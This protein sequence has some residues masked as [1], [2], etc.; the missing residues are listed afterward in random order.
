[1]SHMCID[2]ITRAANDYGYNCFL[3]YDA[4]ASKDSEF[5]KE[6]KK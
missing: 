6:K 4:C 1:M 5:L 2:E 3:I